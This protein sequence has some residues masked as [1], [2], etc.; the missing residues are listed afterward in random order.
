MLKKNSEL[1]I[2]PARVKCK[3]ST[4]NNS[5]FGDQNDET[6]FKHQHKLHDFS[7]LELEIS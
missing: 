7:D 3:M 5:V 2:L 4:R 1:R 6:T